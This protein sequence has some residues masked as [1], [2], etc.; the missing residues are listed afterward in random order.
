MRW[1]FALSLFLTLLVPASAGPEVE[2]PWVELARSQLG[3]SEGSAEGRRRIRQYHAQGVGKAHGAKTAWCAS[4][5]NWVLKRSGYRGTESAMA[6]SF[7]RL[8][9]RLQE[10]R[11][12]CLVV[13]WRESP[14]SGLGHVGI[15]LG[16]S[17]DTVQVLGGN[18]DDEVRVSDYAKSRV[19]AYVWP[20]RWG[21]F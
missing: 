12:G 10:P 6:R 4:F 5:L 19:T 11:V 7:E 17:G 8:G 3:V 2:A 16:E 13:F 20:E 21:P 15:W 1:L 9:T 14:E 18:Q